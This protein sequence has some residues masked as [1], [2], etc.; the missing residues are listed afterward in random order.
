MWAGGG[1]G[2]GE[3]GVGKGRS[4]VGGGVTGNKDFR[5]DFCVVVAAAVVNRMGF[6][7]V[8]VEVWLVGRWGGE[9]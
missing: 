7:D 9:G 2:G 6:V 5:D 4:V 1:G 3:G 8:H